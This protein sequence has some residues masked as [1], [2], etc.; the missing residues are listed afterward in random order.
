M[1]RRDYGNGGPD[2]KLTCKISATSP[3]W[4]D[5]VERAALDLG[6]LD[7]SA[8]TAS[9]ASGKPKV[10]AISFKRPQWSPSTL[11]TLAFSLSVLLKIA[12]TIGLRRAA[13]YP[14]ATREYS[15]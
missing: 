1:Q 7:K 10:M 12:V 4:L 13:G 14:G 2:Q 11:I 3:E 8:K 5:A 15:E 6:R 9:P